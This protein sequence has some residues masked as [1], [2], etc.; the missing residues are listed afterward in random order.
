MVK[1]RRTWIIVAVCGVVIVA[2]VSLLR[3]Y[4]RPDSDASAKLR[5]LAVGGSDTSSTTAGLS[6]GGQDGSESA[7]GGPS[8][9]SAAPKPVTRPDRLTAVRQPPP[10]TITMIDAASATPGSKYTVEFVP[11][12]LGPGTGSRKLVIAISQSEPS[13]GTTRPFDFAKKNILVDT[14]KL[15]HAQAVLTGGTYSAQLEL[16]P[17]GTLLI[18]TLISVS[19][20]K[21]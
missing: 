10:H 9:P 1:R 8:G 13:P 14:A 19:P 6:A 21:G 16:V 15:G 4:S 17:S 11:Y 2:A 18:P 5:A 20:T 7:T 12:G 3:A